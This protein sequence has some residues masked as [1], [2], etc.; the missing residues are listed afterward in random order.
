MV[1]STKTFEPSAERRY[2]TEP[3]AARLAALLRGVTGKR[4]FAAAEIVTHWPTIVGERLAE[5][6]LPERLKAERGGLGVGGGVLE[7]RV[8]GP[9][10][11]EL[12]HVEPQIIEK[13]NA[14]CGFRAVARLKLLR[15]HVPPPKPKLKPL[16]ELPP[17][18]KAEIDREVA[19]IEDQALREALAGLGRAI[20]ARQI[21]DGER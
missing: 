17:A 5:C 15:G 4:G 18:E 19:T 12:Q 7:V 13:V 14:F 1:R 16:P 6:T 9:L 20:R 8:D 11:L 3:A 2:R 21:A 10:A